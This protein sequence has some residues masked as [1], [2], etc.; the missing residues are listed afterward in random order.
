MKTSTKTL[1]VLAAALVG[2]FLFASFRPIAPHHPADVRAT[3]STIELTAAAPT[4]PAG[5]QADA[6]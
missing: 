2:A 6:W 4:L 1:S 3:I 5:A